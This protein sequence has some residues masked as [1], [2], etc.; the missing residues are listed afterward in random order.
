M[1]KPDRK[2]ASQRRTGVDMTKPKF[3]TEQVEGAIRDAM[4]SMASA[5]KKLKM[6]RT[7]LYLYLRREP[8]LKDVL[9][10][11]RKNYKD[12]CRE[13]AMDNHLSRLMAGEPGATSYELAKLVP[14]PPGYHLDLGK[15]SSEEVVLLKTLLDKARPDGD[16]QP[17]P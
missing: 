9:E 11:A 5:A 15:L 3:T 7:A 13:F 6:N 17:K 8:A 1:R 4:G 10:N 2:K 12:D 14:P 16:P